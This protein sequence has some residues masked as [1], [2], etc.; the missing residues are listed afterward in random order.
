MFGA[1]AYVGAELHQRFGLSLG[2]VGAMLASFGVGALVYSLDRRHAGARAWASRAL[3]A[4]GAARCSPRATPCSRPCPRRGS[5]RP[6][7][8]SSASASTC[9]TT[10]CRPTPRRW[11]PSRGGW[12]SRCSHSCC[13]CGQSVGV[14]L[15][16][17]VMDRYGARPIFLVS[18]VVILAT[19][20]SGS[21]ASCSLREHGLSGGACPRLVSEAPVW[22]R[23]GAMS[24]HQDGRGGRRSYHHGNLREALIARRSI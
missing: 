10:R 18:V 1:L 22:A 3:P 8:P 11:R 19:S 12:R 14:A 5:R 21:A 23:T 24:W 2:M 4:G 13:S 17:P 15:A 7:S 9:C 16:A 20:R 6:P